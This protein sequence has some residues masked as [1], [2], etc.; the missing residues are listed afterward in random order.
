MINDTLAIGEIS[1]GKVINGTDTLSVMNSINAGDKIAPLGNSGHST[2]HVH[3]YCFKNGN[4]DYND[5]DNVQDP[6]EFIT[7]AQPKYNV[8]IDSLKIVY[9]GDSLS[10]VR[11]RC[12]MLNPDGS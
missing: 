7:H 4:F 2:T 11:V 8:S 3:V 10:S 6:L 5:P 9:P 1:G 12:K